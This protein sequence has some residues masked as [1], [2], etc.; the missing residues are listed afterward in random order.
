MSDLVTY[1]RA[2]FDHEQLVAQAALDQDSAWWWDDPD[3]DSPAEQHI[4]M[5]RPEHALV[6][7]AAHRAILDLHHDCTGPCREV[8]A[9][10]EPYRDMPD[11]DPRWLTG[12]RPKPDHVR[13]LPA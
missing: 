3:C 11:F 7:I 4:A 12:H 2:K 5:W 10:A 1:L 6:V 13:E 9:L 8:S